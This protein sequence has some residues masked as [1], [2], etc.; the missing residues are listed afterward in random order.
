MN[1]HEKDLG[2]PF[3][4]SDYE[5]EP[6]YLL[7]CKL[8]KEL[9]KNHMRYVEAE[10][11]NNEEVTSYLNEIIASRREATTASEI[12]DPAMQEIFAGEEAVL[13]KAL[14]TSVFNDPD[15]Y[16]GVGMTAKASRSK[17]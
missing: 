16:L 15:N 13:F 5:G 8:P 3:N 6:F 17:P 10:N 11:M 2:V 9:A 1:F 14:E 12:S 4:I 7:L